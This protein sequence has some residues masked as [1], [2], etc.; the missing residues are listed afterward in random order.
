MALPIA[1][2]LKFVRNERSSAAR[3]RKASR[4]REA[5]R[6]KL[7]LSYEACKA[8]LDSITGR[9]KRSNLPPCEQS[10]ND[11]AGQTKH[12]AGHQTVNFQQIKHGLP[13][14]IPQDASS[15]IGNQRDPGDQQQHEK[16]D[17]QNQLITHAT[18]NARGMP[19]QNGWSR[20]LRESRGW[21]RN[22][23]LRLGLQV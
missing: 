15:C 20:R 10:Q 2:S 23:F 12:G 16:N 19:E 21:A 3:S 22:L 9:C 5:S 8:F 11:H 14:S 1:N 7:R 13:P 18:S 4:N 6:E 17:Y